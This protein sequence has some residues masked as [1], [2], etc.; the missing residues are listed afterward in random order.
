MVGGLDGGDEKV[1]QAFV[2]VDDHPRPPGPQDLEDASHVVGG[3]RVGLGRQ[4][5]GG[6]HLEAI[7]VV[8]QEVVEDLVEVLTLGLGGEG[9]GDRDV[10][11][12]PQGDGNLP[13]LQVEVD[14]DDGLSGG[15][16]QEL[17]GIGGQE[18]LAAAARSRGDHD[19]AS[20]AGGVGPVGH[21]LE[22]VP[23]DAGGP[24]ERTAQLGVVGV[25]RYEVVGSHPD[26]LGQIGPRTLV[27]GEH[28]RHPRVP[29]VEGGQAP[30]TSAV[31]ER[32]AGHDGVPVAG[33]KVRLGP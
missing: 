7:G 24:A 26:D 8:Q 20:L 33:G 25:E 21:H 3:D 19:D 4:A 2:G 9:V 31:H 15:A 29:R 32:R 30:K 11:P 10:G 16:G 17:G 6:Q 23:G 22:P 5:G 27:Q 14:E 12:Q 1:A 28:R 13:E 18:G